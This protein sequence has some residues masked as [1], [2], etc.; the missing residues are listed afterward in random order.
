MLSLNL[1]LFGL[2]P[3][4]K[5]LGGTD[6]K[7][8]TNKIAWIHWS[9]DL[10]SLFNKVALR[11]FVNFCLVRGLKRARKGPHGNLSWAE[12]WK[13]EQRPQAV[14]YLSE[15]FHRTCW[16]ALISHAIESLGTDAQV[17]R[18][19]KILP[20]IGPETLK[21]DKNRVRSN[22][23]GNLK[24]SRPCQSIAHGKPSRGSNCA[25]R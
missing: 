24:V 6:L 5:G 15:W 3:L 1:P 20:D 14:S 22:L 19:L 13:Q 10:G 11:R 25:K 18:I 4:S 16:R 9:L 23:L 21:P 8:L 12:Y 17:G 7:L 2:G